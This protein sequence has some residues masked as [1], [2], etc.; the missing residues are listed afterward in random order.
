MRDMGI[1]LVHR[2]HIVNYEDLSRGDLVDVIAYQTAH[3]IKRLALN[4]ADLNANLAITVGQHPSFPGALT[5]E[6]KA[7]KRAD[8]FR[9]VDEGDLSE[10]IDDVDDE[11]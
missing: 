6:A 4:G 9:L 2:E 1:E 11:G 10:P 8:P 5:I 3:A 7:A